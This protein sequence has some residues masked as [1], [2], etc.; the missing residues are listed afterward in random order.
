MCTFFAHFT[1]SFLYIQLIYF[2]T[3]LFIYQAKLQILPTL[4]LKFFPKTVDKIDFI[5]YNENRKGKTSKGYAK[6]NIVIKIT[7]L[8]L[9]GWRYFFM[10]ITKSK[11]II[12][13]EI[14]YSFS[15]AT[16]SFCGD[17]SITA[18]LL[19]CFQSS[20]LSDFP[21]KLLYN[22]F[23]IISTSFYKNFRQIL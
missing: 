11:R 13:N 5:H 20:L 18:Q 3:N 8:A 22:T 16:T 12:I 10:E 21:T 23:Y 17:D 7:L 2:I 9:V 4:F 1:F 19:H 6:K 15:I 14:M